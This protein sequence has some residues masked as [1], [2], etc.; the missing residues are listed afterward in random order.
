[1]S[2]QTREIT[3]SAQAIENDLTVD[4]GTGTLCWDTD[5]D[6]CEGGKARATLTF[7]ITGTDV[8]T[9]TPGGTATPESTI[10]AEGAP[11]PFER[12]VFYVRLDSENAP[13]VGAVTTTWISLGEGLGRSPIG[14]ASNQEFS[15]RLNLA[16]SQVAAAAGLTGFTEAVNGDPEEVVIIRAVGY[17]AD[18]SAVVTTQTVMVTL[19]ED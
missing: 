16:G 5:D 8:V 4:E 19:T 12:V 2:R 6:G 18:G 17:T 7:D 15:W 10:E 11:D 3:Y 13:L 9:G 14:D 1:M